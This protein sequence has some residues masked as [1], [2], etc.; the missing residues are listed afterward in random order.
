VKRGHEERVHPSPSA[1]RLDGTS[2]WATSSSNG[3]PT[4][5][6]R[7]G[8][9]F[10]RKTEARDAR[11]EPFGS[12]PRGACRHCDWTV[13][14]CTR[15]RRTSRPSVAEKAGFTREG[16]LHAYSKRRD[17]TRADVVIYALVGEDQSPFDLENFGR[18]IAEA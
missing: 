11:P 15:I 17:G 5:A 1:R 16:V 10:W 18:P 6:V 7:S 13:W 14:S 2:A 3:M 9:G 8:T 4:V 12:W